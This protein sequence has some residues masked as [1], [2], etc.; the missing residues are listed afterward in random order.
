MLDLIQERG[1]SMFTQT[2]LSVGTFAIRSFMTCKAYIRLLRKFR[3]YHYV[4]IYRHAWRSILTHLSSRLFF[5]A[6]GN[7][8]GNI[9]PDSMANTYCFVLCIPPVNVVFI[10]MLHDIG[11]DILYF[12]MTYTLR[13]NYD[14][15][16]RYDRLMKDMP[17][18]S[19]TYH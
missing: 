7:S 15:Y 19:V 8:N 1:P 18:F 4:D 12:K 10:I 3:W 13:R 14:T 6:S 5:N 17:H 9:Y 11:L 2:C 16:S